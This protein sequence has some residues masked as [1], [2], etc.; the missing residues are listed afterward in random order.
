MYTLKLKKN[1]CTK[2][3]ND[4]IIV[5]IDGKKHKS[6]PEEILMS[7]GLHNIEIEQFHMFDNYLF[8]LTVIFSLFDLIIN[9]VDAGY[10]P[11]RWGRKAYISFDINIKESKELYVTLSRKRQNILVDLYTL[12]IN[13]TSCLNVI[14]RQK[15]TVF[16]ITGT[17]LFWI[18]IVSFFVLIISLFSI[19]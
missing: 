12:D 9:T 16:T 14:K 17:I 2:T 13:D 19:K 18:M 8:I 4:E 1:K 10:L 15:V 5:K 6:N 3:I 7:E 11:R